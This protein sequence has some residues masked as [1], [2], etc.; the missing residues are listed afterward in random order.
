MLSVDALEWFAHGFVQV[1]V[2]VHV[3]DVQTV[4]AEV[5]D[6]LGDGRV[7]HLVAEGVQGATLLLTGLYSHMLQLPLPASTEIQNVIVSKTVL[8]L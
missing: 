8:S 1:Q 4:S 3:G 2:S 5:A 6:E 7:P